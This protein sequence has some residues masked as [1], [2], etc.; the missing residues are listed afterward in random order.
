M[1]ATFDIPKLNM[2]S[3]PKAFPLPTNDEI[4]IESGIENLRSSLSDLG[5]AS[6][7]L[8]N[9]LGSVYVFAFIT[10]VVLLLSGFLELCSCDE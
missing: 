9:N 5:Y 6:A 7:Y 1:V 3:I 2:E 10:A 4:L 8:S